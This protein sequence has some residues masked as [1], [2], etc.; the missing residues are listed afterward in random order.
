M[1]KRAHIFGLLPSPLWGGLAV[2]V[3]VGG[4]I[5]CNNND[6]LPSPPP[7]GGREQAEFVARSNS[8]SLEHALTSTKQTGAPM[9]SDRK[10]PKSSNN[11][12][13]MTPSPITAPYF[14]LAPRLRKG[15][16]TVTKE[17]EARLKRL[18]AVE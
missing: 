12:Q 3:E 16:T 9:A 13:R 5:S 14:S 4:C 11:E 15:E 6:P 10:R 7:Q 1:H 18:D 2:G 17:L 8:N